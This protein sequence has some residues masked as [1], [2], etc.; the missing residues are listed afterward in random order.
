MNLTISVIICTRNRF[1]DFKKTVASL[2]QQN[3]LPDELIVVDSSDL[4][5]IEEYLNTLESPINIRY[6]HTNPGLTLQR[7]Y[8]IRKSRGDLL[9][10]FDDDVDLDPDYITMIEKTFESDIQCEIGAVGGRI[11]NLLNDQSLTFRSWFEKTIF[12]FIRIFFGL[13]DLGSGSYR[14]SGMPTF[15]HLF[16]YKYTL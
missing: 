2:M 10:F 9:F 6:F 13:E 4:M 12:R 7:N 14:L 11:I 1:D 5:Q 8:G 3:R 16:D 15:P